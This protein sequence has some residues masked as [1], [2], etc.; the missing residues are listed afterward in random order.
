MKKDGYSWWHQRISQAMKHYDYIRC[1]H[2]RGFCAFYA[3][4]PGKKAQEGV[5]L[6]GPGE[7]LFR[8]LTERLGQLPILA[9][10]LGFLDSQVKNLLQL[11]GYPGMMVYQFSKDEM[12]AMSNERASKK[13]FY[14]GTH[15]NPSLTA[16]CAE[17][18]TQPRGSD[19]II[20]SLYKGNGAWVITPLQDLLGLGDES[21]MNVPGRPRGNWAWRGKASQLT[22]ELAE[23][24]HRWVSDSGR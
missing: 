2:F 24:I 14:T 7:E 1:D 11:C 22:K 23:K 9:E 8:C 19:A 20:E 4:P 18:T 21:R 17:N 6:P 12:L 5:W 13:V 15:D 3:I 10:D 16:W